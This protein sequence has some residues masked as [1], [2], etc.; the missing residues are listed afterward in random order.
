MS[1]E[2]LQDHLPGR[3]EGAGAF[4]EEMGLGDSFQFL[5][6]LMLKEKFE[7]MQ[8]EGALGTGPWS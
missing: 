4:C 5:D 1:G 8:E 7:I 6:S 3:G 2:A